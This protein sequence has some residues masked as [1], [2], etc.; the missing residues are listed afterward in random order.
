MDVDR[1]SP[2]GESSARN[3]GLESDPQS[4][5]RLLRQA[6]TGDDGALSVLCERYLPRLRRW[7]SGRLPRTARDLQETDD[8]VQE[9]L[10]RTIDRLPEI[11]FTHEGAFQAYVRQSIINRIRDEVRRVARRPT[12]TAIPEDSKG[13]GPS[14]LEE[15]IGEEVV[16]RYESALARLSEAEREAIHLRVELGM[17]YAEAAQALGK[18]SEDAARMTVSRALLRLAKEMAHGSA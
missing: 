2:S 14:P 16:E 3:G 11:N 5:L 4:T 12:S 7:A 13:P 1:P 18:P 15:T 8:L 9:T 17:S 6:Q 10:L